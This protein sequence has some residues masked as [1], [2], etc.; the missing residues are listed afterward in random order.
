[1]SQAAAND[2]PF[3]G[4]AENWAAI[5]ADG[6]ENAATPM[7]TLSGMGA[8][9]A[10]DDAYA[11][12]AEVFPILYPNAGRAGF[13][14][15]LTSRIARYPFGAQAPVAGILPAGGRV[16]VGGSVDLVPG[17]LV[18]VE[19]GFRL[20][21]T[22]RRPLPDTDALVSLIASVAPVVELPRNPFGKTT[23]PTATDLI[24]VNTGAHRY[25]VGTQRALADW[26]E[27]NRAFVEL[28]IDGEIVE[29]GKATN[30]EP[31]QLEGLMWLVN[32]A[33]ARG[34]EIT[35]SDL[36]VTGSMTPIRPAPAGRYEARFRE[37]GVLSF[38]VREPRPR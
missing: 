29:R 16:S 24:A 28:V 25:L 5:V 27:V 37:L 19:L 13:K 3:W 11:V 35:P 31:D 23:R 2:A 6:L 15:G 4:D 7:P 21:R 8:G 12:Q 32:H 9:L 20:T 36:L 1:M 10:A 26:R 30:V 22:V 17:L 33:V 38:T 18:E 34:Y 14:A